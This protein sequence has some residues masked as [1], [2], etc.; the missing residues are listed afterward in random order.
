MICYTKIEEATI[1]EAL[2]HTEKG[3]L[4]IGEDLR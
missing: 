4:L 1:G 2:E 3:L